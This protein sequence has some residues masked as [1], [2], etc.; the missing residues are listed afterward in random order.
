MQNLPRACPKCGSVSRGRCPNCTR[1][2]KAEHQKVRDDDNSFYRTKAWRAVRQ[3]C[4][5]RDKWCQE[6]KRRGLYTPATI[7]DHKIPRRTRPD[8]ALDLDNLEGKC[9]PCHDR[10]GSRHDRQTQED[11]TL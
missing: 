8:L 10:F 5:E 2:R 1:Q 6:C 7:A 4:I 3:Q 11:E 9:K